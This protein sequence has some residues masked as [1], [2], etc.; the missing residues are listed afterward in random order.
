MNQAEL[1]FYFRNTWTGG[2]PQFNQTGLSL[3]DRIGEGERVI[4]VGCGRNPFKGVIPNLIGIDPAFD[5][6]DVLATIE[7]FHTDEKFDVALCLGSINF[8]SLAVITRQIECVIGM[9][10]PTGRIYWRC[11]PGVADHGNS[12]CER[13]DFFPW[14]IEWHSILAKYYGFEIEEIGIEENKNRIYATWVR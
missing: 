4:D 14:T 1:N 11:N 12:E 3:A 13:I 7:N 6:A 10:T 2:T 8:G 5:E 9:L